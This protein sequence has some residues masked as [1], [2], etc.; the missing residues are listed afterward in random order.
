MSLGLMIILEI[1]W[2]DKS[3]IQPKHPHQHLA[4]ITAVELRNRDFLYRNFDNP[5]Y[6]MQLW[7][8]T[9]CPT[10]QIRRGGC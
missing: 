1:G 10:K 5:A 8:E 9:I 2:N 6:D 3:N 4:T 7:R